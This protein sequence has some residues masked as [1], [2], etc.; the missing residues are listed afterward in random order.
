[1]TTLTVTIADDKDLPV[2][3][4]IFNRFGLEYA[5]NDHSEHQLSNSEINSFL[6]SKDDFLSGKTTAKD[7]TKIDEELNSAYN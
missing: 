5:V 2:L 7:W 3:Q 6:K 1:M 4:E